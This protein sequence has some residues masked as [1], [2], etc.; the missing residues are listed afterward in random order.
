VDAGDLEGAG[1]VDVADAGVRVLGAHEGG[2]QRGRLEVVGVGAL[3]RQ[4]A[5][6]LAALHALAEQAGGH[7]PRSIAAAARTAARI[8]A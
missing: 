1:D 7:R 4:Q 3:A 8:P 6:V 2:L 5:A